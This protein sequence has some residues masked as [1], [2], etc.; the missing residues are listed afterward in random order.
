VETLQKE[1]SKLTS[2]FREGILKIRVIGAIDLVPEEGIE[3]CMP[4]AIL[5][6]ANTHVPT[7]FLPATNNP[8]WSQAFKFQKFTFRKSRMDAYPMDMGHV[9]IMN[10][11]PETR[12][13]YKLCSASFVLPNDFMDGPKSV[14]LPLHLG[15][16]GRR[17]FV[18]LSYHLKESDLEPTPSEWGSKTYCVEAEVDV[19]PPVYNMGG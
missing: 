17:G 15:E 16:D 10:W 7:V 11:H 13:A 2:E 4:Y 3:K 6:I 18:V 8:E 14:E 12:E 9:H 19:S 1:Q 5:S